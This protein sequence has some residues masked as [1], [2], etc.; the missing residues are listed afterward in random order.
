M[1]NFIS[2]CHVSLLL[3]VNLKTLNIF[4]LGMNPLI[5]LVAFFKFCDN[6]PFFRWSYPNC[7]QFTISNNASHL[8]EGS[9]MLIVLFSIYCTDF[10]HSQFIASKV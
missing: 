3:P 4:L 5:I 2:L 7:T 8:Y 9:M 10:F 6:P 1:H